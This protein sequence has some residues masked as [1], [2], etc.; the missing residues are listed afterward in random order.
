MTCLLRED[1]PAIFTVPLGGTGPLG[2]G[3]AIPGGPPP[4]AMAF[5]SVV[6]G[7]VSGHGV[8][9]GAPAFLSAGAEWGDVGGMAADLS[10]GVKKA[11]K[12]NMLGGSGGGGMPV[13]GSKGNVVG[14]ENNK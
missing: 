14:Q 1:F 10:V 9:G 7:K 2:G 11:D 8:L 12:I 13:I 4:L 5:R 3:G 6:A